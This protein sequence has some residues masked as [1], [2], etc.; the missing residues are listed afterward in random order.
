MNNKIPINEN[1]DFNYNMLNKRILEQATL[2]TVISEIRALKFGIIPK[3]DVI[4]ET[5]LVEPKWN[6]IRANQC[7]GRSLRRSLT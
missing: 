4:E 3:I 1:N 5:Y 6:D 7:I 2:L